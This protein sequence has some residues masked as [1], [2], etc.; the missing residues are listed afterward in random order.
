MTMPTYTKITRVGLAAGWLGATGCRFTEYNSGHCANNEGDATCELIGDGSKPYCRRGTDECITPGSEH[1]CV[2]ERPEDACYSPCGGRSTISENGECVMVEESSSSGTS[3]TTD[4]TTTSES[5]TSGSTTAGPTPC[6]SSEDCDVLD[7]PYCADTGVCVPCNQAP[8]SADGDAA[9][10]ALEPALP[11]CAPDGSCVQCTSQN[12][13]AC[14]DTT[15]VCDDSSFTCVPCD[16]HD[17]CL[18]AAC[19]LFT[20]ACLPKDE[21]YHVG[22]GQ[23][24]SSIAAAVASFTAIGDQGTL[25]LH[26]NSYNEAV[27]VDNDRVLAFLAADIG[28]GATPP[29]W[30]TPAGNPSVPQLSVTTGAT[31]FLDG[32]QL[33]GNGTSMAPGLRLDAARVWIDRTRV[34]Q[35][36][37]GSIRAQNDAELIVR[38]CFVGDGT[39]GDHGVSVDG[40][41]ANILSTTVGTGVD[42]FADVFPIYCNGSVDVSIR[43][44]LLVSFDNPAEISCSMATVTDTASETLITGAGN[45]ALGNVAMDW[46]MDID[47]GDFHLDNPPT[48][49]DTAARWTISDP[50]TDIDG[51]PRPSSDASPDFAG[52]DVP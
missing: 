17:Q 42:N 39:N 15:P 41:L 12:P 13:T 2:A 3:V 27:I 10:A 49:L 31:A 25:I 9:C 33:S 21:V 5:T 37:G 22:P 50:P 11:A 19:N 6:A 7:A 24:Y 29:E 45:V 47:S 4:I 16:A 34:V 52:A 14:I 44:S 26:S 40:S 20:G 23:E 18:P 1:G 36:A 43:N 38:N 51:D 28:E 48:T 35:N 46:F 8:V 32:L 30:D